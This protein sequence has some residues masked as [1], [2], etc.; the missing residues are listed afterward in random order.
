MLQQ[1]RRSAAAAA[2][3]APRSGAAHAEAGGAER[4]AS[5]AR[6]QG[7]H[8]RRAERLEAGGSR[9]ASGRNRKIGLKKIVLQPEITVIQIVSHTSHIV[10][11]L[12]LSSS[13][14]TGFV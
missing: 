1:A 12:S 6:R 2:A 5:C 7:R 14:H 4:A 10:R 3:H 9:Q 11:V 8:S 13:W